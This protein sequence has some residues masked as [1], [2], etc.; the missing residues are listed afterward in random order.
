MIPFA[1]NTMR[2]NLTAKAL[3]SVGVLTLV[4]LG[5]AALGYMLEWNKNAPAEN[6]AY[7]AT[8]P[9]PEEV[10]TTFAREFIR[11]ERV[12][13]PRALPSGISFIDQSG[14]VQSFETLKGTPTLINFWATWCA[15]CV[16]E[17]PTLAALKETYPGLS[18]MAISLDFSL[19]IAGVAN[20]LKE[21]GL[22][23]LDAYY[24]HE[25]AIRSSI[26]MKGIPTS[27]LLGTDGKIHYI[28]EGDADWTSSPAR[29]FFD[30]YLL[31]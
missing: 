10:Y 27:F 28:F 31:R 20:F 22:S 6:T 3:L 11:V 24:D 8:N 9:I 16:T 14:T 1:L 13:P 19:D 25:G 15:P 18:V 5:A 21:Q 23:A 4:F 17:L 30:A 29:A 26:P 7:S 2:E 12:L